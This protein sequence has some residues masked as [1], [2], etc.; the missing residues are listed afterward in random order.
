MYISTMRIKYFG[1]VREVVGSDDIA[2]TPGMTVG[3]VRAL[4]LD[5]Y[6]DLASLKSLMIARNQAYALDD[7]VLGPAD[8]LAIIPPVSGG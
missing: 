3:E 1:I 6:P 4:L 2:I 7:E 8:E 5:R